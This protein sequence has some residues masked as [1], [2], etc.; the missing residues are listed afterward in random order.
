[1][2]GEEREQRGV[3]G[4]EREGKEMEGRRIRERDRVERMKREREGDCN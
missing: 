2:M 1:M 4:I 3:G